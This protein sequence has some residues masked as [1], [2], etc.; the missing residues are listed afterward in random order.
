MDGGEFPASLGSY[1][2]ICKFN[3]GG[4]IDHCKYTYLDMAH[5]DVAF[6]NCLTVGGF[7]YALILVDHATWCNWAF[8]LKNLLLDAILAAIQLFCAATGSLA[9]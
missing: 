4:P 3:S 8:G 7:R 2:T 5:M 1:A 6:G 9:K